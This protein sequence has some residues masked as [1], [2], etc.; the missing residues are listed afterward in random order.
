M[1]KHIPE[2]SS[3][4]IHSV[5]VSSDHQRKGIG[6]ALIQ[7]YVAR[8]ERGNINGSW[9]YR[10]LLLITHDYLRGFYENAGFE[11]SGKS[12]VVH[13]SNPWYEM[14]RH[15]NPRTDYPSKLPS[16]IHTSKAVFWPI[17]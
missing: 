8:L 10:C 4:C 14:R 15:L 7:E 1:S 9:S 6:S 12:N 2:G 16:Q 3:V 17:I 13:G 11:W 5:C